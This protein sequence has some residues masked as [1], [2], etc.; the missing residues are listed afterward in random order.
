M[1]IKESDYR[2]LAEE[3]FWEGVKSVM[4]DVLIRNRLKL[5]K[6]RL[7]VYGHFIETSSIRNI[8][9]I[10]AGKASG[11]MAQAVEEILGGMI[12]DGHVIVKYGHGRPLKKITIT[13]A[14]HPL[15]DR[16]GFE[17]TRRIIEIAEK[18]GNS[19]LVLCLISGGG[20]ALLADCPEGATE[21]D[22]IN[23]NE[24]LVKSGANIIEMN[25]VRKHLSKVKGGRLAELAFPA[26]LVNLMISDV[27]GDSPS[28]IASGPTCPD[29][30]TFWDAMNI[31]E[32]YNLKDKFPRSLI[33]IL[34]E[35]IEGKIRETPKPGD[36]VF[37]KTL[38]IIAG[39]NMT[40]LEAATAKAY[41]FGFNCIIEPGSINMDVSEAANHIVDTIM[42]YRS[43]SC[44][45]KPAAVLFGGESTVKVNG[46]G[47]GGRNQHLALLCGKMI[48]NLEG[49]TILCAGTDGTDGPT[50]VAGAIVDCD[51]W[52]KAIMNGIDPEFLLRNFDSY[53]F[54]RLAGGHIITGPTYTNVMDIA[55]ALF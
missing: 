13:E 16:N 25:T 49:V 3:I 44:F 37:E 27:P 4:P 15:P 46:S 23:M 40:A 19:D 34:E 6:K 10:G 55:I 17:G 32:K 31:I 35:G 22:I 18:A 29:E 24:L 39:N 8:Y 11:A 5:S 41:R 7:E 52:G 20:S 51:T 2:R 42:K 30:S 1:Q 45:K 48:R 21:N 28:V 50:D 36:K 53:N 12:S 47:M 54:F 26:T 33:K 43:D 14:G 38:N 9:V